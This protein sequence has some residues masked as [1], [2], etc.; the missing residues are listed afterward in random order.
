MI[1]KYLNTSYV[2]LGKITPIERKYLIEFLTKDA[3][4]ENKARNEAINK[5]KQQYNM[6]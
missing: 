3:E 4:E 2:E 1:S 6:N 5:A